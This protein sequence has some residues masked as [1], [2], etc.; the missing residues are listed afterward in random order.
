MDPLAQLRPHPLPAADPELGAVPALQQLWQ[1]ERP[2]ACLPGG[3]GFLGC[4]PD[5]LWRVQHSAPCL[6]AQVQ[7]IRSVWGKHLAFYDLQ[8]DE[9]SAS[10]CWAAQASM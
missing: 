3:V 9:V 6:P 1:H 8:V 5:R 10:R 7:A 4:G 2:G